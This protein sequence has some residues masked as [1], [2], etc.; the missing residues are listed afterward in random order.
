M[1][2]SVVAVPVSDNVVRFVVNEVFVALWTVK[3]A[4]A[5]F[6]ALFAHARF[7]RGAL[8]LSGDAV[9]VSTVGAAGATWNTIGRIMS[10]SS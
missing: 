9:A 5:G 8:E 2:T 7:T 6:V 10:F 4:A 3:L 1:S